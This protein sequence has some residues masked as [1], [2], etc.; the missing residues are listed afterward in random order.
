MK[1]YDFTKINK[2]VKKRM[3]LGNTHHSL[4]GERLAEKMLLVSPEELEQFLNRELLENSME[5]AAVNLGDQRIRSVKNGLITLIT[6][7][8]RA[9]MKYGVDPEFAYTLSDYYI[10]HLETLRSLDE[11]MELM[12][13]I[14]MHYNSLVREAKIPEFTGPIA[15][16]VEYISRNL[17]MPIKV[18]DVAEYA[19]LEPHYFSALFKKTT[20]MSPHKYI[21]ARKFEKAKDMLD[22]TRDPI[23]YI[24]GSLG[25]CD[26]SH[27]EKRFKDSFGMTPLEYRNKKQR[28]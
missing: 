4:E 26:A 23:I 16:G 20:G 10:G 11:L 5:W 15:R 12:K 8:C 22:T 13:S 19:G 2:E 27:F 24:A 18:K 1:E 6:Q 25:F 3:E 9:S 28:F 21:L 7:V 17:Y 14:M